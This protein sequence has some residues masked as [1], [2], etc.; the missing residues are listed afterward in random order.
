MYRVNSMELIK[1]YIFSLCGASIVISVAKIILHNSKLTKTVNIFLSLFLLFYMIAP[2]GNQK[3]S[4]DFY[5]Y[6]KESN[7]ENYSSDNYSDFITFAVTRLCEEENCT[8]EKIQ[9]IEKEKDGEK[10]IDYI[11]IK[12][13][14]SS[15]AEIIAE[16]LK[17]EYGFEVNVS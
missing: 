5:N 12:L 2:F 6:V 1:N 3:T 16:K 14:D 11:E 13:N 15:K 4:T 7:T 17:K 10:V 8:A 9:I